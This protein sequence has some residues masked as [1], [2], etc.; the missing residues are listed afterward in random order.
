[1]AVAG[2]TLVGG[3][4]ACSVT[5]ALPRMACVEEFFA[6]TVTLIC[7]ETLLGAV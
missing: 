4:D 7:V 6:R 3:G 2:L 1:M 5:L